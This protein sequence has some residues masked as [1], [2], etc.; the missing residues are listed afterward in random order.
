MINM[1]VL[2]VLRQAAF[3]NPDM[4]SR[5]ESAVVPGLALSPCRTRTPQALEEQG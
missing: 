4:P 3:L 1:A 2:Y 5:E